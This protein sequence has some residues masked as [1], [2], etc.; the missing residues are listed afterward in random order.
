MQTKKSLVVKLHQLAP[1]KPAWG[2]ACNGCGVCCAIE[3]CPVARLR[4][5]KKTGPCPAL[6]WFS[7]INRYQCGLLVKPKYFLTAL[8]DF[9]IPTIQ[10]WMGRWIAA[11]KGCDCAAEIE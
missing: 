1:T 6:M 4:F 10:R 9:L 2:E 11:G 7:P 3:T 8:P 5:L